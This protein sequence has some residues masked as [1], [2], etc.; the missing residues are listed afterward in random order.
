MEL[1][2]EQINDF[3]SK[4]ILESQI[5]KAVQDS[6]ARVVAELSKSYNN[7]FD[8]VIKS[9][10]S[11]LIETEVITTYKPLLEAGIKEAMAEHMTGDVVQKIINSAM[12]KMNSRY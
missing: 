6:V 11:K 8:A 5:G 12:E 7:P 9:Q 10:V 1:T 3:I 2:P 4:A